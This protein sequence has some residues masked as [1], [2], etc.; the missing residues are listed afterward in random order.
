[1]NVGGRLLKRWVYIA[2]RSPRLPYPGSSIWQLT[3]SSSTSV[4][5]EGSWKKPDGVPPAKLRVY[6]SLTRSKVK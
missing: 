4:A 3:M 5:D 6:N 1:M 2:V